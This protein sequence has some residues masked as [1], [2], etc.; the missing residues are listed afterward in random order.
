LSNL[1]NIVVETLKKNRSELKLGVYLKVL[2]AFFIVFSVIFTACGKSKSE[3]VVSGY[4]EA[5]KV[6]VSPRIY[7]RVIEVRADEGDKVR[8]GDTLV[9]LDSRE[10]D[11]SLKEAQLKLDAGRARIEGLR[12]QLSLA[13]DRL[14]DFENLY[15]SGSI[16]EEKLKELKTRVD[17]LEATLKEAEMTL[18]ST[19]KRVDLLKLER[20][21]CF[22]TAPIKGVVLERVTE[23]GEVALP[24]IPILTLASLDT[25]K[26]IAF[27]P[28]RD[29]GKVSIGDT[30]FISAD[31][32]PDTVF[33]GIVSKISDE[34]VFVPK[35]VQTK[36]ERTKL[37]FEIE[38]L[39]P[40]KEGFLKPGM[41]ADARFRLSH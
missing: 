39:V 35:N 24:G 18:K 3:L 33:T 31:A 36:E 19:E 26:M 14:K 13:Q 17:V 34:T 6:D 41:F 4:I 8:R 5:N 23:P 21:E 12:S 11:A 16:S 10:F 20:D 22:L 30:A 7:A 28:E 9:I 32:Y 25:L 38:I 37:V 15:E 40:N 2:F 1:A 29:M 27:L